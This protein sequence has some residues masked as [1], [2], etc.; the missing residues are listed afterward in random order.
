MKLWSKEYYK[1][2]LS[3]SGKYCYE[4]LLK[5]IYNHNMKVNFQGKASIKSL[6][7]EIESVVE[8][9]RKDHPEIF[10]INLLKMEIRISLFSTVVKLESFQTLHERNDMLKSCEKWR[11][12][13]I[14]RVPCTFNE[15]ETIWL[16]YDYLSRQMNYGIISEQH[17]QTIISAFRTGEHVS[18]CEGIS[19]SFKYLCDS[20]GIPCIVVF[21]EGKNDDNG[22]HAWNIV[23]CNDELWHVD[24]TREIYTAHTFGRAE[25]NKFLYK[26][27]EMKEYVWNQGEVPKCR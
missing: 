3:D 7:N 20:L 23:E 14:S 9:I 4:E 5:N 26:D 27:Y 1:S 16:L 6:K 13:V 19:K 12:W 17:S 21:G 18:V 2:L 11:D 25:R 15:K 8:A 24:V 22:G 10:W